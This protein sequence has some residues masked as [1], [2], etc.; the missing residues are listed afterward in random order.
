MFAEFTKYIAYENNFSVTPH[1][2]GDLTLD[3]LS[4]FDVLI[5]PNPFSLASDKFMDWV[6]NPGGSF[7]SPSQQTIAVIH[8]F[9][10]GGGGLLI[11]STDQ[12]TY[13]LTALNE[14]LLPFSIQ[15][16]SRSSGVI[17]D[18]NIIDQSLNFTQN[19]DSYPHWG[20]YLSK[21]GASSNERILATSSGEP[22][23]ITHQNTAGGKVIVFGSDLIFDNL[24]FSSYAYQGDQNNHK[25]LAFNS[26]A[27]LSENDFITTTTDLPEIP[28]PLLILLLFSAVAICY[29]IYTKKFKTS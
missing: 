25:I 9:V 26:V 27:W 23:L 8:Q 20:N 1:V 10:S 12:E 11:L 28:F 6:N 29:I 17:V 19:I 15:V 3:L 14:F 2:K 18:A 24:G 21:I 4:K 7:M 13:N 5:L 22:T 16:Q